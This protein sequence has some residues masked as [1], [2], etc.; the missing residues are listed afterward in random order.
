MELAHI[1]FTVSQA[2]VEP[3]PA[4]ATIAEGL[5]RQSNRVLPEWSHAGRPA[6]TQLFETFRT[7]LDE[8]GLGFTAGDDCPTCQLPHM[9]VVQVCAVL[10]GVSTYCYTCT[11][12]REYRLPDR[13]DSQTRPTE[14]PTPPAHRNRSRFGRQVLAHGATGH[15]E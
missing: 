8:D 10:V 11:Y 1:E 5:V 12:Q 14:Q 13:P 6:V 7:K 4:E 9:S 2:G 3:S 15:F